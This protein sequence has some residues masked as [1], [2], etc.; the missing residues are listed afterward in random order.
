MR[1]LEERLQDVEEAVTFVAMRRLNLAGLPY[2]RNNR[3][4]EELDLF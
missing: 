1:R 4:E 3:R 2:V